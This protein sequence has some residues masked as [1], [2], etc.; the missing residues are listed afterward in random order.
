MKYTVKAT[1]MELTASVEEYIAKKM[2]ALDKVAGHFG[3]GVTA[4]VEAG[5]ASRHHR[6]G[7]VFRVELMVYIKG[8]DLRAV[9]LGKTVLE[10][11]DKAQEDMRTEL[12]RY[13]EKTVDSTKTG[14]RAIKKLIKGE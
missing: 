12:E 7:N 11:M 5:R 2:A 10:A 1:D 4:H 9:S 8:K 3:T 6:S 14:G 13:K